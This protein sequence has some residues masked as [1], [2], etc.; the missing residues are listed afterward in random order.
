ITVINVQAAVALHLIDERPEQAR[1]ALATIKEVSK[2]TL[3]ELRAVLQ[4]LRQGDEPPQRG[5]APSLARLD[6]LVAR[7]ANGGLQTRTEIEG[8]LDDL[9]MSVAL[10]AYRIVQE[11]LT[12]VIRHAGAASATVRVAHQPDTLTVQVDDEGGAVTPI[13]E[14]GPGKGI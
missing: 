1:I 14:P 10:A 4:A 13:A 8:N 12:N 5:P 11:S 9:P 2:E 6:E 7:A 3:G